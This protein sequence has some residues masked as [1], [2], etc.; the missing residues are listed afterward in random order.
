MSIHD[1]TPQTVADA[2]AKLTDEAKAL[3]KKKD[4]VDTR[5]IALNRQKRELEA[6]SAA[7]QRDIERLQ[8]ARLLL[9]EIPGGVREL[10]TKLFEARDNA[11]RDDVTVRQAAEFSRQV[12]ELSKALIEAC[13]HPFVISHDGYKDTYSADRDES[14][15]GERT[16]A[17]C[18]LH[19]H[20]YARWGGQGGYKALLPADHRLFAGPTRSQYDAHRKALRET[21]DLRRIIEAF[22]DKRTLD[23]LVRMTQAPLSR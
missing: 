21:R 7:V 20:E 6:Q 22:S 16:C 15:P 1:F 9:Q 10:R 2:L 17:V 4:K 14:E 3:A 23:L 12:G 19:E 18:D 13:P 11:I 5:L 8:A